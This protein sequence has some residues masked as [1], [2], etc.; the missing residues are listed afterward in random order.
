M[1]KCR[2][3]RYHHFT[4]YVEHPY[5]CSIEHKNYD[6]HGELTKWTIYNG[7]KEHYEGNSIESFMEAL[8]T[9]ESKYNLID[10]ETESKSTWEDALLIYIDNLHKIEGFFGKYITDSFPKTSV[11]KTYV[12]IKHIQFRSYLDWQPKLKLEDALNTMTFIYNTYF[13]PNKYFYLTPNQRIRKQIKRLTHIYKDELAK[14]VYPEDYPESQYLKAGIFGGLNYVDCQREVHNDMLYIDLKSAYIYSLFVLKHCI[15]EKKEV[16]PKTYSKYLYQDKYGSI[17]QYKIH[18]KTTSNAIGM[19]KSAKTGEHFQAG[20]HKVIVILSNIDLENLLML[21]YT[22]ILY[23]ECVSLVEYKLGRL[24]KGIRDVLI[25]EFLIKESISEDTDPYRYAAQKVVL[26]GVPGN[27]QRFPKSKKEFNKEKKN[28]YMAPQWGIFLTAYVRRLIL[29]LGIRLDHWVYT[30]TDS[31]VCKNNDHNM[32]LIEEFNEKIRRTNKEFS[33]ELGYDYDKIK[34]LGTFDVKCYVNR[35]IVFSPKHYAYEGIN[36]EG[37]YKFEVKS[38]GST[39]EAIKPLKP[40]DVFNED[41]EQ[42]PVG[43]RRI[44][45]IDNGYYQEPLGEIDVMCLCIVS[46]RVS[47]II[48]EYKYE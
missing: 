1:I 25:R 23:I 7:K 48:D 42:L 17:G 9:L 27:C 32:Q 35:F 10:H 26:N 30:D 40:E 24:G 8:D 22:S 16:D 5:I 33:D 36:K 20:E 37:K 46:N 13:I 38:S 3:S 44:D 34:K 21:P 28:A 29:S 15:G 43:T 18:Y 19:F 45:K 11:D 14:E 41:I 12:S 31:I 39:E 6:D 4:S 47:K 2:D